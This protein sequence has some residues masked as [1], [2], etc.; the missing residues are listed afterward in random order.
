MMPDFLD[1]LYQE[2][3][4]DD[5]L[6]MTSFQNHY[7]SIGDMT[8]VY[9]RGERKYYDCVT[10]S[11][12]NDSYKTYTCK[13]YDEDGNL[14][15]NPFSDIENWKTRLRVFKMDNLGC[16]SYAKVLKDGTCRIIWRDILNNGFN[17]SDKTVEEYPFTNGAFYINKRFDIYVKRQDPYEIWGLY[18]MDDI[19]GTVIYVDE[20]DNYV[21]DTEIVC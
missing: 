5:E 20:E 11:G 19:E 16:P 21:K 2:N 12:E 18:S 8:K 10:V 14:V 13:V 7:L 1:I 4:G 9:D 3:I 17:E 15:K 6:Q